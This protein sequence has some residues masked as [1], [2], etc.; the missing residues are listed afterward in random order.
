[1]LAR[2]MAKI[3]KR[4]RT[5]MRLALDATPLG[6]RADQARRARRARARR[7]PD[8]PFC[9]DLPD[10]T[11]RGLRPVFLER[12]S[13]YATATSVKLLDPETLV[14]ASFLEKRLYLVRFDAGLRTHRILDEIPTTWRGLAVET[15]LADADPTG[16]DIVL[17]SFHHGSFTHYRREGD[18]L[19]HVRDLDTGLAT[20][21]HGVR[22]LDRH[23]FAGTLGSE[24]TGLCFFD[25][26][27]GE[28]ILRL[29]LPLKAQDSAFL[30]DGELLAMTVHG[31]PRHAPQSP[32]A[33]SIFRVRFDLEAGRAEGVESRR[34]EDSHFDACV[35]H[36]GRLHLTDQR[37]HC[38]RILDVDTLEDVGRIEGY[39][40]PHGLDIGF[41]LLAVSSYGSNAI[42]L[43]P[44]GNPESIGL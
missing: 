40:F 33:S 23:V 34:W 12:Q 7:R 5:R 10:L 31:A 42:D 44:M 26:E 17:S 39:D 15:D 22:F 16:R 21:V 28:P 24:P 29:D 37:N 4:W 32:Y 11:G 27:R 2:R 43:R 14:C 19:V 9:V 41:G 35:I 20:Q 6:G 18:R 13:R 38:V 3:S 1:M 8:G 30:S 25:L 36:A